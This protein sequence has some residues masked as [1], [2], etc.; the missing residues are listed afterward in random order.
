MNKLEKN[1]ISYFYVVDEDGDQMSVPTT[2]YK[3]AKND[4]KDLIKKS[5]GLHRYTI[6]EFQVEEEKNE[7]K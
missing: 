3:E 7:K 5:S 2:S 6:D 4:L 1:K